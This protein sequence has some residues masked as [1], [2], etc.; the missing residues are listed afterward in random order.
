M[1]PSPNKKCHRTGFEK[2][3]LALLSDGSCDR[4]KMLKG[5][6]I[7]TKAERQEWGCIDDLILVAINSVGC[8]IGDWC[9]STD[10]KHN[11]D[12][13]R[14]NNVAGE[15]VREIARMGDKMAGAVAGVVRS[16]ADAAIEVGRDKAALDAASRPA[17]LEHRPQ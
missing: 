2:C 15:M 16:V 17:L 14:E 4:W 13:A 1:L 5:E 10:K 8:S 11:A 6:D 3:C 12:V 9:A 7:K